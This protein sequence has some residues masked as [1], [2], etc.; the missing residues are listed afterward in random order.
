MKVM[1]LLV[2]TV[3]AM[4]CRGERKNAYPPPQCNDDTTSGVVSPFPTRGRCG[5]GGSGGGDAGAAGDGG[6]AGNK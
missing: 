2:V 1:V 6:I 3:L 4:G 5:E